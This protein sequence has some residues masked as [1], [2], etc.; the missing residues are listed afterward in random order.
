MTKSKHLP[1][2]VIT[3]AAGK[4]GS[5]LTRRLK[6]NYQVVGLDVIEDACDIPIDITSKHSVSLAFQLFKERYGDQIAAFIHLAAYYDFT[7]EYSSMYDKVNVE[8]TRNLLDALQDFEVEQMIYASTMLVQKPCQPG[9]SIDESSPLSPKW[10]YPKSKAKTEQV[11]KDH[12]GNIPYLIFRLAGLYDD[13]TCVPTLAHQIARTYE[14]DIKSKFFAGDKNSGQSFIHLDDL[15]TLFEKA[16]QKRHD[17]PKTEVINAGEPDVLSYQE[18]QQQISHLIHNE[19]AQI[20]NLPEHVAK[21]GAWL[22]EKMEPVV[23][24]D[25]DQGEKPFIRSFMIDLASDH[26]QL[27]ITKAG[28]K[29]DWYPVHRIEKTLPEMIVNLKKNP[30]A[31]YEKN[32]LTKPDWMVTNDHVNAEDTR[33]QFE[34]QFRKQHQSNLWAHFFN[35]GLGFWLITSPMTM[36]YESGALVYSDILSGVLLVIL[37]FLSLSWRLAPARWACA[38]VGLWL[39]FAPLFFWVPTAEAYLNDTLVGA[40]VIGLS[41]LVRPAVGVAPNA[42]VHG[43]EI[44]PGWDFSPSTWF[45]RLPIIILAFIGLYIS[46][47]MAAYQLGHIDA[48]W[49]PFFTGFLPDAKNGTEE[50]ITSSVSEVWPVPDAGLG[51][52]VYVLEILTGLIGGSSR[53]RTMPWLVLFFGILIVPLGV[54]SITFIIIQPII[55]NTWCTLCLIAAVAMLVQ[56]PYSFDE[57]VATIQFLWRRKKAGR[58]LLKIL[59]VGDVDEQNGANKF[60]EDNFEQSPGHIIKD[61]LTGGVTLPWTLAGC[62]I[63]G[64]WLMLTRL[65]IG[66][67]GSM[68]NADHLIGSLI[69]TVTVTALA[70]SVRILRYINLL[71][72]AGLFITPYIFDANLTGFVSSYVC[73]ALLIFLTLP[74]GTIHSTYGEWNRWIR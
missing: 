68:A 70:E 62:L 59:F 64:L 72:A 37:G 1:I 54:V 35:I 36:S 69:I 30:S 10:A 33:S 19:D 34:Y 53:W 60:E 11:I 57:L 45:Q 41:V 7:G 25:F 63:I 40:L 71:L 44:P 66:A 21:T 38:F 9:E 15:V 20:I 24:D 26:Y 61:M 31:W 43:P 12:H 13:E 52:T 6:D 18:L 5:A 4:I 16:I 50:I 32:N 56:V 3:G 48:V 22:E 17:L 28:E 39:I 47:Y 23:P 46:R 2:V 65:I 51:A 55:L 73:G 8:G 74:K 67:D 58:P 29:L 49:D 42:A 14:R 27:D